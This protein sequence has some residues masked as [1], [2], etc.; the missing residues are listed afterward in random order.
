M[1]LWS[2]P[3]IPT[4]FPSY[5]PGLFPRPAHDYVVHRL[6]KRKN[7]TQCR[8]AHFPLLA[9]FCSLGMKLFFP[10]S[11]IPEITLL[12]Y[13]T[14]SSFE[15]LGFLLDRL[16]LPLI[17]ESR[18]SRGSPPYSPVALS[19]SASPIRTPFMPPC[20]TRVFPSYS[21]VVEIPAPQLFLQRL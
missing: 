13:V 12:T 1:Y 3:L 21:G 18:S 8:I 15:G 14:P 6:L 5:N 2:A 9:P 4:P 17:D 16:S 11:I 20:I 19:A 7:P 10:R